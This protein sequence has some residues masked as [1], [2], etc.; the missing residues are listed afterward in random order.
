MHVFSEG[1]R[2]GDAPSDHLVGRFDYLDA[3]ARP[4][5]ARVRDLIEAWVDDYPEEHRPEMVRRLRSRSDGLHNSAFFE[6]FLHALLLRRGFAIIAIEPVMP[7]G[8]APDFL[9]EAPDGT[10][11]YLEATLATGMD[12]VAVGADRRMRDALQAIDAVYSP[13]FFLH[14]HTRGTPAKQVATKKLQRSVQRFVDGLDRAQTVLD[15]EAGRPIAVWQQEE[16]GAR[17]MIQP[18]PKNTPR[19]GGRAIGGRMLPAAIVQPNLAIKGAVEGKAGRYGQ[20]DIPLV[21]AVN[22]MEEFAGPEDAIDAMFGTVTAVIRENGDLVQRR[23]V[24][25]AWRGRGGPVHTRS[26]ALLIVER[27]SGWSVAQ[28]TARLILNPWAQNPLSHLS[29]GIEISHVVEDCLVTAPGQSIREIFE[30][31]DGWPE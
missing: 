14:L 8:R 31:P 20:L 11:F 1:A 27:L 12:D 22:A 23:N 4:E 2:E 7:N 9:V 17:F 26:S 24:D 21:V 29:F 13:D 3:S 5:A 15:V 6:L 10:R 19:A 25:G 16:H 28:R 30:L 18:V